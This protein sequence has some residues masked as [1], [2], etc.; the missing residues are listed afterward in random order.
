[1]TGFNHG[2]TGGVIALTVKNPALA[3]PLSLISHFLM[4]PI[5]HF[6]YFAE[7]SKADILNHKFKRFLVF[8]F[9]FS[10]LLMLILGL[11][12]PQH[13][14]LIWACMIAA[15]IP[16]A[17]WWF[18]RNSADRWPGNFDPFTKLHWDVQKKVSFNGIYLEIA[19][20]IIM[21]VIILEIR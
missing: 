16:D 9:L 7:K 5:P 3:V 4:D 12:F 18:Y 2:I 21:S 19:W 1:M 14:W 15:A 6:H 11:L 20:L 10:V 13:R 8:D 17:I